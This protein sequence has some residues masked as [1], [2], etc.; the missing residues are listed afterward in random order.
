MYSCTSVTDCR[1]VRF[2]PTNFL[3]QPG[4]FA[5]STCC[6]QR[7]ELLPLPGPKEAVSLQWPMAHLK[8]RHD[9]AAKALLQTGHMSVVVLHLLPGDAACSSQPDNQR[10]RDGARAK[11]ALLAPTIHLRL[12]TDAWPPAEVEGADALMQHESAS[13]VGLEMP[14]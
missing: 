10:R 2:K 8:L 12:K 4:A 14:G 13:T 11:P 7:A 6:E 1:L 3:V 9:A 5:I